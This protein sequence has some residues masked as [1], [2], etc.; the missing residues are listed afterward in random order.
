MAPP[1]DQIE[2]EEH[3]TNIEAI[4]FSA[5]EDLLSL[6]KGVPL[7]DDPFKE[8]MTKLIKK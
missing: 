6:F 8:K 2:L 1:P 7:K 5:D 3:L 4:K